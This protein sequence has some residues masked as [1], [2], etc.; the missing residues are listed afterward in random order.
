[1]RSTYCRLYAHNIIELVLS[2]FFLSVYRRRAPAKLANEINLL[3]SSIFIITSRK[4]INNETLSVSLKEWEQIS[5]ILRIQNKT[6]LERKKRRIF[7]HLT[8]KLD[9]L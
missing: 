7:S 2:L 6:N 3:I 5:S 8:Y 9:N 4:G 1:M